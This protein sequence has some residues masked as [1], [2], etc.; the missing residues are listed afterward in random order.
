MK[1]LQLFDP[2]IRYY[3]GFDGKAD[4][5]ICIVIQIST[6]LRDEYV[7]T[8]WTGRKM[9]FKTEELKDI[10]LPQA[11]QDNKYGFYSVN[12]NTINMLLRD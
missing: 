7:V 4:T 2:V 1:E 3:K 6:G 8:N 10:Y 5:D 9:S 12:R 11:D